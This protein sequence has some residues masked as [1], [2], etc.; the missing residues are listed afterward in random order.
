V[1]QALPSWALEKSIPASQLQP[2][3][4]P[5]SRIILDLS[6]PTRAWISYDGSPART[7]DDFHI[8]FILNLEVKPSHIEKDSPS[9]QLFR[10]L[11]R[12]NDFAPI[13]SSMG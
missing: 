3:G 11:Q 1:Q 4:Y 12:T 9:P 7:V 2:S 10:C 13:P 8:S 5:A 6:E